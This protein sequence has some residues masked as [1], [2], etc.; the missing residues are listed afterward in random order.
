M[1]F[2]A[3]ESKLSRPEAAELIKQARFNPKQIEANSKQLTVRTGTSYFQESSEGWQNAKVALSTVEKIGWF[4][5]SVERTPFI[6]SSTVTITEKGK[7]QSRSWKDGG[8][9]S[10]WII[11]TEYPEFV[12][13]SGIST[14][15]PSIAIAEYKWRWMPTESGKILGI[16]PGEPTTTNANFRLYDDGWRIVQ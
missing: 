15:E 5:V 2:A 14:Q 6:L 8:N 13:V 12:E 9:G 7:Q 10:T 1:L 11:A 4:N 3:S 16:T